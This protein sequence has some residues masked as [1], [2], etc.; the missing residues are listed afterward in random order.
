MLRCPLIQLYKDSSANEANSG[1][2]ATADHNGFLG[3]GFA[4]QMSMKPQGWLAR[5]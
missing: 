5:R 3:H 1:G 4:S 2:I